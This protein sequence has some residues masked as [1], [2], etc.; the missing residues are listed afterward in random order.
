MVSTSHKKRGPIMV[1]RILVAMLL[2]TAAFFACAFPLGFAW[3]FSWR[4]ASGL[5]GGALMVLA[6][7]TVL[8]HVPASRRGLE[9]IRGARQIAFS[10]IQPG[11]QR[12][13][14]LARR[15]LQSHA[16]E[17]GECHEDAGDLIF[18]THSSPAT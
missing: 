10:L 7:P 3:F 1:T 16:A 4:F 6:A 18:P 17:P 2:A 9:K 14:V 12:D 15:L 8:P 5:A 11:T 13:R